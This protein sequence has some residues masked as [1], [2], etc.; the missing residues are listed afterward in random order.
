MKLENV[1]RVSLLNSYTVFTGQPASDSTC[2][3]ERKIVSV[4]NS[5]IT[6]YLCNYLEFYLGYLSI[7]LLLEYKYIINKAGMV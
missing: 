3:M 1:Y 5:S 2:T 6:N 4:I 7:V